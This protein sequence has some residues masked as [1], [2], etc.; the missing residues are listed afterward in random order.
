[1]TKHTQGPWR[2]APANLYPSGGINVDSAV[3]KKYV[4]LVAGNWDD[5]V[6]QADA[7]LIAAAPD[8]LEALKNLLAVHQGEGGTKYHAVDIANAAIAKAEGTA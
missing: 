3:E 6:G 8:M 1:M 7:R 5:E 2:V 4:C